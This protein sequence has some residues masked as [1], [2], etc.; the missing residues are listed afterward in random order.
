MKKLAIILALLL[1]PMTAFGMDTIS[2]SDL[3]AVTGQAGVT[4]AIN[5][6][7]IQN[8][9]GTTSYGDVDQGKW[10]SIV[11]V[12]TRTRTIGFHGKDSGT[13]S[14]NAGFWMSQ[15]FK[16]SA[17][18]GIPDFDALTID[19]LNILDV[20]S[21]SPTVVDVRSVI[22]AEDL[23][24]TSYAGVKIELCDIIQIEEDSGLKRYIYMSD[25]ADASHVTNGDMII[26]IY[27]AA[28]TTRIIG[29]DMGTRTAGVG[30]G[31]LIYANT[32]QPYAPGENT[33]IMITAHGSMNN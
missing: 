3:D 26:A 5:S 14:T 10:I 6:I 31:T 19:V 21:A 16:G 17:L 32:T 18:D 9:S 4:I 25:S 24:R 20:A 13:F 8:T 27:S 23:P 12:G 2:D 28:G 1:I 15:G 29:A 30:G 22:V 7:C 11:Q 33:S